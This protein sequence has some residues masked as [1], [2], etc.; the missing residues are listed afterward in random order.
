VDDDDIP[1]ETQCA[2]ELVDLALDFVDDWPEEE[3]DDVLIDIF[4]EALSGL[5]VA[6]KICNP[7]YRNDL[8]LNECFDKIRVKF[9]SRTREQILIARPDEI[10]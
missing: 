9:N 10:N 7:T 4:T 1:F 8:I 2:G 6:F 5:L 3:K